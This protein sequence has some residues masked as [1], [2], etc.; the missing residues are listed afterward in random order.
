MIE[1]RIE[2]S[3]ATETITWQLVTTM[4]VEITPEGATLSK[5]EYSP[6]TPVK[7][8]WIENLSHPEIKMSIVSLDPPPFELDR[9][10]DGLKRIELKIL[11]SQVKGGKLDIQIKLRGQ[12]NWREGY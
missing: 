12:K 2:I 8:L 5:P 10:I 7:K 6:V 9:R 3:E 4:D 1:D 11:S